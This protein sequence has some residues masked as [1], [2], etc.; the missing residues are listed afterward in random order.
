MSE[1]PRRRL[2]IG[3]SIVAAVVV[4]WGIGSRFRSPLMLTDMEVQIAPDYPQ[5]ILRRPNDRYLGPAGVSSL[6]FASGGYEQLS[7]GSG[8]IT[9]VAT[10]NGMPVTGLKVRLYFLPNLMSSWITTD[11]NGHYRID[12]P[13][14]E[15]KIEGFEL[16]MESANAKL[17]GKILHPQNA[18]L[19]EAFEVSETVPGHGLN[20]AFVDA[21]EPDFPKRSFS[22]DDKEIVLSW[23]PIPGAYE[24]AVVLYES[25]D[26][27]YPSR[28]TMVAW[29]E[30]PLTLEPSAN[31][32][33]FYSLEESHEYAVYV[34]ALNEEGRLISYSETRDRDFDF[35]IV[36]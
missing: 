28:G 36:D 7:A 34:A 23:K 1:N 18:F 29:S 20:L 30:F 27:E 12:V 6:E 32:L 31:L 3:V 10:V 15:Y 8:R 17:P 16:D 22:S 13:F 35:Q 33:E 2:V 21:I 5:Y 26:S 4:L 11:P 14:G 24:Y 19:S 25:S 9:G